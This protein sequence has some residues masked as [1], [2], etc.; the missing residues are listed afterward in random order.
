[1][2]VIT[3]QMNKATLLIISASLS[4]VA[5]L[6]SLTAATIDL[7]EYGFQIDAIDVAPGAGPATAL[8]MFL[9]VSDGFAPNVSVNIQPYSGSI[10]DYIGLSKGQ[11]QQLKL[12]IIEEKQTGDTEWAVEY[13]GPAQGIDIHFYAR[14]VAKDGRVYLITATAK[15]SQWGSVGETLRKHVDSFKAK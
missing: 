13:K 11:F 3:S 14:A 6:S 2:V 4:C 5:M 10:T 1:M 9:P 7:P 8:M 12:T 15:E